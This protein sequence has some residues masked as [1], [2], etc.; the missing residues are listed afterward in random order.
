MIYSTFQL[1]FAIVFITIFSLLNFQAEFNRRS[2]GHV[3]HASIEKYRRNN[4]KYWHSFVMNKGTEWEKMNLAWFNA[5]SP[6]DKLVVLYDDLRDHPEP[7]LR[8]ILD[9]LGVAITEKSMGCVMS[10][11]EGIYKRNKKN[12]NIEVFDSEM[13]RHLIDRRISL[14]SK[15]GLKVPEEDL[16]FIAAQQQQQQ[17]TNVKTVVGK[18]TPSSVKS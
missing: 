13:K 11:K 18:S 12:L 4:G 5:F 14:Y 16:K 9:F 3:G 15:I 17:Q 2:G 8:R 1:L 7:Q 6:K 10:R